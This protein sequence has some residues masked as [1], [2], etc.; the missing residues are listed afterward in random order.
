VHPL[1]VQPSVVQLLLASLLVMPMVFPPV[2]LKLTVQL[3]QQV[4]H[5]VGIQ[6]ATAMV[7]TPLNVQPLILPVTPVVTPT[8]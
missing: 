7:N 1:M 8:R 6:L 5:T 2:P 4:P 3:F